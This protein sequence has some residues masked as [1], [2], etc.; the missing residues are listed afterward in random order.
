M[1]NPTPKQKWA[2]TRNFAKLRV[3][4]AYCNLRAIANSGIL[5]EHE[6]QLMDNILASLCLLTD[7]WDNRNEESKAKFLQE[8]EQQAYYDSHYHMKDEDKR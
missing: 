1:S 2:Q 3:T 8:R 7:N 6:E 4:G 5:A